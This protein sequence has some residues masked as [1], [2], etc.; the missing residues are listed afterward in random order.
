MEFQYIYLLQEREFI[1]CKE[2]VYKI[3]K[4]K[5]PYLGRFMSYP[6]ASILLL[7]IACDNCTDCEKLILEAFKVKYIQ[8]LDIGYEYFQGNIDTM[9]QD[10]CLLIFS[11]MNEK[12]T[13]EESVCDLALPENIYLQPI[14]DN[15]TDVPQHSDTELPVVVCQPVGTNIVAEEHNEKI[16]KTELI[17]KNH[18]Y[19][20]DTCGVYTVLKWVFTRHLESSRHKA[21]KSEQKTYDCTKCSKRFTSRSGM[22]KHK[23]LG[24]IIN[25]VPVFTSNEPSII[26]DSMQEI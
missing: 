22:Y 7:H 10:I 24:K 4:T 16:E 12:N 14:P 21:L 8:R 3:G 25:E 17:R 18:Y 2:P 9:I 11:R 5:Q 23:C 15:I 6:K 20:C 1:R 26:V 13:T 19:S